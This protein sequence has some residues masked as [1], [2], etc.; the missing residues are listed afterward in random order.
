[1][2]SSTF[3]FVSPEAC[4]ELAARD[5]GSYTDLERQQL[6]QPGQLPLLLEIAVHEVI[7]PNYGLINAIAEIA[8][9][10]QLEFAAQ[11]GPE[12]KG[13]QVFYTLIKNAALNALD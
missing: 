6:K 4:K 9:E 13:M 5:V 1:V 10:G 11:D 7:P 8:I 3:K 2:S 12:A